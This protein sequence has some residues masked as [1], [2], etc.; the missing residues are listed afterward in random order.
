MRPVVRVAKVSV[1]ARTADPRAAGRIVPELT[2]FSLLGLLF[3][4][5]TPRFTGL[6]YFAFRVWSCCIFEG[7]PTSCAPL[8][9]VTV[10]EVSLC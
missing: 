3:T 6:R 1:R 10:R 5:D 2:E 8:A 4:S 9:Y 7:L